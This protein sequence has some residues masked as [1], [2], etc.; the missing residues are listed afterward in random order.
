MFDPGQR[1]AGGWGMAS[2]R[3]RRAFLP[4]PAP[5]ER[6][7]WNTPRGVGA[8]GAPFAG[9]SRFFARR[10]TRTSGAGTGR[11]LGRAPECSGQ[12]GAACSAT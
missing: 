9:G 11:V 6:V 7:F 5:K 4:P 8:R 3:R 1:E 10:T 12:G 2:P